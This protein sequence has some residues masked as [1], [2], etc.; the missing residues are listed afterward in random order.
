MSN[1]CVN[2]PMPPTAP[3]SDEESG[4][5]LDGLRKIAGRARREAGRAADALE[6]RARETFA[7]TIQTQL[8]ARVD[9][10]GRQLADPDNIDA[11]QHSLRRLANFTYGLG[12]SLD[13]NARQLS[14]FLDWAERRHGR[15]RVLHTLSRHNPLTTEEFVDLFETLLEAPAREVDPERIDHF[16]TVGRSRLL[17]MMAELSAAPAADSD[18]AESA[19]SGR[20][21]NEELLEMIEAA[22][23]PERFRDLARQAA[24]P[25][26]RD[27]RNTGPTETPEDGTRGGDA[28]P[29]QSGLGG[30]VR[31]L[32]AR[33]DSPLA[34]TVHRL[35]APGVQLVTLS[36]VTALQAYLTRTVIDSLPEMARRSRP[37]DSDE[38]IFDV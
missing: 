29:A 25:G 36:F 21:S 22:A 18:E 12:F 23:L 38:D 8:R 16:E 13:P 14:E 1:R 15:S 34:G 7:E 32:V 24:E 27:D 31:A 28:P 20:E 3:M 19:V 5:L 26:D 4:G 11:L 35:M 10:I 33:R 6:R 17:A 2:P 30:Q 9:E 37:P